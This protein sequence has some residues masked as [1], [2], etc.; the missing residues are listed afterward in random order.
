[1]KIQTILVDDEADSLETLTLE[2][3]LFEDKIEIIGAFQDPKEAIKAIQKEQP[4]LVFLD[5]EMPHINGLELLRTLQPIDFSVIFTTA[6][7]Q[8]A[9]EAIK[10][11]AIDY[12]LKPVDEEELAAA[13]VKVEQQL[14]AP[15]SQLQIEMLFANMKTNNPAFPKI[16]L[17]TME[18]LQFVEVKQIICCE[19]DSNY[20]KV[21]LQDGSNIL[22]SKT[23]KEVANK[24]EGHYFY[25]AHQ[26]Y[27]VNLMHIKKYVRGKNGYLVMD[28]GMSIPVA[29]SRKDDFLERF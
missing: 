24:L 18:G 17:P 20:T 29:R 11:S 15:V 12:L 25:R 8:F 9:L 14:S 27:L 13:I 22:I 21:I 4:Q 23:L 3:A 26:T 6:Y 2:L 19:A 10:M 16:A 5:I 28:N 1:M 7:S